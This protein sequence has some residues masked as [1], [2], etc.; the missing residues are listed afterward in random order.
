[1]LTVGRSAAWGRPALPRCSTNVMSSATTIVIGCPPWV[2]SAVASVFQGRP[3]RML[4][5]TPVAGADR[6]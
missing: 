1:M 5:D 2:G 6:G 3:A 4:T